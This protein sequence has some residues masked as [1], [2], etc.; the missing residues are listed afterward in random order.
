M[1]KFQDLILFSLFFGILSKLWPLSKVH[2]DSMKSIDKGTMSSVDLWKNCQV[3]SFDLC[4]RGDTQCR[5]FASS[6]HFAR[7]TLHIYGKPK[8]GGLIISQYF[9]CPVSFSILSPWHFWHFGARV[10]YTWKSTRT[11]TRQHKINYCTH[12]GMYGC[13]YPLWSWGP[14]HVLN[15]VITLTQLKAG[16]H[17]S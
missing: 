4:T 8:N 1:F 6:V 10:T 9:N 7:L 14:Q 12:I 17:Y 13:V 16:Q 5:S 2:E 3:K 15:T 11:I